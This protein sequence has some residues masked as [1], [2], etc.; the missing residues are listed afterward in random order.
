[1]VLHQSFKHFQTR[2]E[3]PLLAFVFVGSFFL[4]IRVKSASFWLP[5]TL[6]FANNLLRRFCKTK[7]VNSKQC[8]DVFDGI[9]LCF[10]FFEL[11]L[12]VSAVCW[13]VYLHFWKKNSNCYKLQGFPQ[14]LGTLGSS[15]RFN[16]WLE[17]IHGGSMG[18]A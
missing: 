1:M 3:E 11:R 18:V 15:S 5:W 2:K 13:K 9:L 12:L 7:I 10:A 8:F 16:G 4:K 14:V 17:S 6:L